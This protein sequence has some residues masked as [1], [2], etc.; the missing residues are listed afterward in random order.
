LL[1]LGITSAE[2][3]AEVAEEVHGS[4]SV[5]L[6]ARDELILYAQAVLNRMNK[7]PP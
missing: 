6:P 1:Q 7:P 5:L 2:E 3:A 4:E